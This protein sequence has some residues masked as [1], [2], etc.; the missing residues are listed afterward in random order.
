MR[1]EREDA[2]FAMPVTGGHG[3]AEGYSLRSH[4]PASGT[5]VRDVV[6]YTSVQLIWSGVR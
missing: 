6:E 3:E 4:R 5:V 1:F 2:S